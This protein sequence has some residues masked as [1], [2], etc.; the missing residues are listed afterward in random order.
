MTPHDT[1]RGNTNRKSKIG[2]SVKTLLGG[3]TYKAQR[4]PEYRFVNLYGM[5]DKTMLWTAWFALNKRA[6]PGVDRVTAEKYKENLD[7]NLENLR[8]RLK[9]KRY[10]AKLVKRRYIPK[11]KGK[12]RPLG[13]PALED[14]IVQK[15][16]AMMLEA[17]YEQDFTEDS[18][19]YR[20]GKNAKDAVKSLRDA[21]NF[22]G[23]GYVVEADIKGFFDNLD[24]DWLVKM[25]EKR[26][27]DQHLIRLIRKWLRAGILEPDGMIINPLTGTPQG[28]IISPVLANI[29]LHYA[30]DL[31]VDRAVKEQVDGKVKFV[32]YADDFVC[33]FTD[34]GGAE[35]FYAQLPGRL[36]K[37]NL[38]VAPDKT[39]IIKFGWFWGKESQRFDF[40]GFELAWTKSRKG[41]P[42]L[43]RRTAR[44]KLRKSL[45]SLTEWIKK[46]RST[47]LSKLIEGLN[48]KLRGYYQYYGVIG[49]ASGLNEYFYQF[50]KVAFKWLNRRSQ[51]RSMNWDQ[52]RQKVRSHLLSPRITE[53]R[54]LQL[55][56]RGLRC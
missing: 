18:Y 20:P 19:G 36:S 46:E 10:R 42:N 6:S 34:K 7:E 31:W 45:E 47:P 48:A 32:R 41:K 38:E 17:I 50:N 24:H 12:T 21:L 44:P 29:Y 51:K 15:A 39:R 37:F 5:I 11:G 28:G 3:I 33:A 22:G 9:E 4:E 53:Q 52:Y 1:P 54:V 30:I 16:V 23:Y 56:L 40:L 27:N 49:N 8:I 43:K 13:L 14:K 55:K 25:L 2:Q 26:I 35:R